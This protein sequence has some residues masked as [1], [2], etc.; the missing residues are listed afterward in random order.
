MEISNPAYYLSIV[1]SHRLRA[2][3]LEGFKSVHINL[4]ED[5]GERELHQILTLVG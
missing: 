2:R 5:F 4:A 3:N 1:C